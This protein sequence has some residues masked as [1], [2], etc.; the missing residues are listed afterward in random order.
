MF[1]KLSLLSMQIFEKL[2]R[3]CVS[4]MNSFNK[5]ETLSKIATHK[6]SNSYLNFSAPGL[7][8]GSPF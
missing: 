3:H 2:C 6:F 4:L 8:G 5:W 7:V 1:M